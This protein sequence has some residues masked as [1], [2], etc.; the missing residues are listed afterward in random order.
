MARRKG[1]RTAPSGKAGRDRKAR[2][3]KIFLDRSFVGHGEVR[4]PLAGRRAPAR[5][6]ALR[7]AWE[8][9]AGQALGHVVRKYRDLRCPAGCH[10]SWRIGFPHPENPT[11]GQLV[12]VVLKQFGLLLSGGLAIE[13]VHSS[14][15]GSGPAVTRYRANVVVR[16]AFVL[17]CTGEK[18][19]QPKPNPDRLL[20]TSRAIF[21][22]LEEL[23]GRLP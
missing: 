7:E 22:L 11:G 10:K 19:D 20:E 5:L 3:S 6:A 16:L 23:A 4:V 17:E 8:D 2:G 13:V 21:D 9:A 18:A 1:K 12:A 14:Q 15:D